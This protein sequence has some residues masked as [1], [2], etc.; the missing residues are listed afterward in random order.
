MSPPR[1]SFHAEPLVRFRNVNRTAAAKKNRFRIIIDETR[2]GGTANS[3]GPIR[4]TC[5]N[6]TARIVLYILSR[7]TYI[8]FKKYPELVIWKMRNFTSV[9]L[10]HSTELQVWARSVTRRADSS[11]FCWSYSSR[12]SAIFTM[13]K[14]VEQRVCIKLHVQNRWKRCRS[15]EL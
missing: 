10:Y 5:R 11:C 6:V 14:L 4:E 8:L 2:L 12:C 9:S 1:H 7:V 15:V 13:G 3:N